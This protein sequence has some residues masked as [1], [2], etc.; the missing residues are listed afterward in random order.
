MIALENG[1]QEHKDKIIPIENTI[2]HPYNT[3]DLV[4][5]GIILLKVNKN[6]KCKCK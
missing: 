4:C 1:G 2:A 6:V 5:P 3:N